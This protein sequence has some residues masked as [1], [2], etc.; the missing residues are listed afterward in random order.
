MN[1][2]MDYYNIFF[3]IYFLGFILFVYTNYQ[4]YLTLVKNHEDLFNNISSEKETNEKSETTDKQNVNKPDVPYEEKYLI[5][6]RNMMNEYV[7]SPEELVK[8]QLKLIDLI[9]NKKNNISNEIA[10]INDKIGELKI[11]YV[12]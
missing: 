6:V 10:Q 3:M 2:Y 11:N 5:Q 7:F 1:Y 4:K 12:I 8:E 9:Q